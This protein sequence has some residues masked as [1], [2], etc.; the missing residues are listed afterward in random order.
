MAR[1]LSNMLNDDPADRA[2][3]GIARPIPPAAGAAIGAE[4][5]D[6]RTGAGA[7]TPLDGAA[8]VCTGTAA[9]GAEAGPAV[10]GAG[11]LIVGAAVGFAGRLIRT[12][13]FFGCTF[14]GSTGFGGT[15]PPGVLVVLSDISQPKLGTDAERVKYYRDARQ[16]ELRF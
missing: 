2:G 8:G 1:P 7:A 13:S 16:K 12:V 15:P 14:T 11:I 9:A 4:G 10:D 5:T 3:D 6:G